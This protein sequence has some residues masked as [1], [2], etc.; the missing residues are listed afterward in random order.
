VSH[1][2]CQR[3]GGDAGDL[4]ACKRCATGARAQLE[5]I[6]DLARFADEKRARVGSNWRVGT[7]GRTPD[8]PLPF[9]PRVSR[10]LGPITDSLNRLALRVMTDDED[11]T[12]APTRAG[13]LP[14][15]ATWLVAQVA[16]IRTWSDA[17]AVFDRI[18]SEA[19][20][21]TR[22]F[23]RP[24]DKVYLG[25][26]GA[27]TAAGPCV[28]DLY[29]ERGTAPAVVVCPRCREVHDVDERREDLRA[30]VDDYLGTAK[31]ISHLCRATLGE[32][33]STN[34]IRYYAR[35]GMIREHGQRRELTKDNQQRAATLYRI[36]EVREAVEVMRV[37]PAERKKAR[38]EAL[39]A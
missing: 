12:D 20:A 24:P 14:A 28:Q 15:V 9:D 33:V 5:V 10:R 35:V 39:H 27:D 18:D 36:G 26:C 37:D 38:R 11:V 32:D 7:I 22:L 3:C 13:S 31:E 1:N 25:A 8:H 30:G 34:M 4:T 6:A 17:P 16:T 29:L 2:P 19:R 21:V 23:D